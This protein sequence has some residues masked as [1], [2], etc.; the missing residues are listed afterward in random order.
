VVAL[1]RV[2]GSLP[3]DLDHEAAEQWVGSLETAARYAGY[4][5]RQATEIER[6]RRQ[7][8]TPLPAHLDYAA[9]RGLSNEIREKLTRVR[10]VDIGQ[11]ARISGMTPAAISLLLIHLKKLQRR[12]A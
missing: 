6:Q 7:A 4:V 5:E 10:P 12:I 3:E 9:V 11:A 8:S 1:E 2:G